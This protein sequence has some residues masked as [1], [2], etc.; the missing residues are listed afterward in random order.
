ME[1]CKVYHLL[2]I[3]GGGLLLV[4]HTN[5]RCYQFRVVT[6]EGEVLGETAIFYTA[7]AALSEGLRW[8]GNR[9]RE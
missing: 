5:L 6:S 7:K 4:F 2:G 9:E 3:K 1:E 8:V